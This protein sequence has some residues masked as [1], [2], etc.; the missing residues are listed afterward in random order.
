MSRSPGDSHCPVVHTAVST[1]SDE[2][3]DGEWSGH[4]A[5]G[6]SG[7]FGDIGAADQEAGAG[8]GVYAVGVFAVAGVADEM[9]FAA[10]VDLTTALDDG[11]DRA[12]TK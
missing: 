4:V 1:T 8:V 5:G 9:Q 7:C 12:V 11:D 10:P 6:S 3:E 2:D